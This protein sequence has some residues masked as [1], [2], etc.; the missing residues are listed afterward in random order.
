[1]STTIAGYNLLEILYEG[2][3]TCVY[4]AKACQNNLGATSVIIKTLKAEY[5]TIGQLNRLKHEYQIL[6]DLEIAEIVEPLA[7]ES[8]GNGLALILSDFDGESLAKAIAKQ[9][10]KLNNFLPIAIHL[11]EILAQLHQQNII[12]KDIKPHNILVNEKTSEVRLIDFGISTRLS[13]ESPTIDRI[14]VLEGTLSYMSP[15]Q[16][17]RMNRSIDYRTDFYSL[18]VTFYEM[19]TGQLPFPATD[20]LE[21]IH[22]HIAKTAIPPHL[23]NSDIPQA[24]SDIVMKLLAKT[25]E[26]RYQSALGLKADLEIYLSGAISGF[27]IGE[28]DL[29]SQFSIPEKLYGRDREIDLLMKTFA[30]VTDGKT[31]VM[32]VKGYSGIGKSSLVNEIR[33]PIVGARGYFISGKFD[34]FQRNIPYSAIITAFQ[35]LVKQL[36]TENEIQLTQWG[37]KLLKALGNNAQIIIDVVP[38]I[39]LIIGKQPTALEL[40]PTEAQNR[41]NVVFQKFI[42]VFCSP[43]HPLVLFLDDLQ[44]ADSAT[45]KL[46]DAILT[47]AET[48]YL[49]L[50]G[51]YRDNEVSLSHPLVI[52]LDSMLSKSIIIHEIT[53][54]PLAL[55]D[56]SNL[57]A[58]TLHNDRISVQTLAELVIRKTSGNPFFVTQFLKTLYQEN[59]LQFNS[60]APGSKAYWQWNITQIEALDITDNVVELMIQKLRKL[61]ESTQQVLQ[62]AACVGN[63]FDLQT[64]ATI[65]KRSPTVTY[66]NILPAIAEGLILPTSE[67]TLPIE[68]SIDPHLM[69]L[70]FKFLHDRVQQAAD[71]LIDDNFKQAT[72]LQIGRLLWQNTSPETLSEK[73]FEIVDHLNLGIELITDSAER[74][75]I[76]K[77]NLIAGQK[78]KAAM[79]SVAANKYLQVGLELLGN[80]SWETE[81]ELTLAL[82]TEAAESAYLSSDFEAV[83][84][85]VD[86][87]RNCAKTLLDKVKVYEIQIQAHV[88]QNK[89]LEAINTALQALKLL[90]VNFP[91][92]PVP[93]DIGQ[94]LSETAAILNGRRIEDLVDLPQMSDPYEL[95]AIKLLASIFAP[96]YIAAPT[97]L[98][99]AV[100]KQVDLSV[101]HGNAPVSP[102]AYANYGLLLCGVVG[103]IDSGYQFGQ[104]ALNLLS[105]L[106]TQ[107]IKA[108]T[109]VIVNIFIRP[110]KEHLRQTLE[111]LMSAYSIGMETGDLEFGAFG[112]LVRS[113]FAYYSSKEL[114]A[115]AREMAINRD[116]IDKIKQKTALNYHEIYWQATLNL[117]G[118]S[119]NPCRLQGEAYDEQIGLPLHEQANDRAAIAYTYLNKLLLCYLFE[120]YSE[121]L[122]NAVIEENY[123]DAVVAT[124]HISLFHFY[125]SLVKLAVYS[126]VPQSE[127]RDILGRVKANQEKIQNWA[128]HAPM[129]YLHKF[130]LVEAERHRVLGEKVEA[131]ELYDKAIAL[132]KE[133][134]YLNEEALA[135]E[136][137]AKFYLSWGKD[138]IAQLYLQ[139]AHYAYQ[140][141]GAQAK[142]EYLKEKY[143]QFLTRTSVKNGTNTTNHQ[144]TTHHTETDKNL[145]LATVMKAAQALSGEIILS[146][147]L[148]KLMQILLENAG[149]ET[150]ILI[151]E[152]S[153]QLFIEA[154]GRVNQDEIT[155]EQSIVVETSQQLPLSIINYVQQTQENVVLNDANREGIFITDSYI[156]AQQPKSVLC[157][158]IV[159]QGKLIGI[160]YLENNLTT[161]AFTAERVE[162]L[163]VLSSQAA[164][165]I[166]N[167][168]LYQDLGTANA[169]LQKSH[170]QLEDYSKTLE[171]K[172]EERT[173]Q[174]RQEVRDRQRAEE[175]AQSANRAKSEFLA[176][177]SHELRTPL[178][179]ILGYTQI[180]RKDQ[181]LSEQQKNRIAIIHQCGEHL[182]TLI[183][184]VLDLSKIEARKMELYPREFHFDEFLQSIVEIC[185]IK[186]EQKGITLIYETLSPLPK[187]VRADDK[188][189]RQILLNLLGNA[190]KFTEMGAIAFKVG[191][192]EEKIRFQIKDSGVGIAA[193]ELDEIFQPFQQ[194]G[195]NSRKTE[196]TGLGL[197]I[198]GQLVE[199]MSGKL[200]VKSSLG[201]GSTFWFDLDLPEIHSSTNAANV[202]QRTVIGIKGEKR[203]ILVVDDKPTNR[204]ILVNF[205][206][207]IGFEVLDAVDGEDGLNKAQVFQPDAILIDLVMPNLDGF[208][209]TRRLRSIPALKDIIVIAISASVFEFDQQQSIKVGCNDFLPKPIREED[210]LEKLQQHLKLEWIYEN[211]SEIGEP[212]KEKDKLENNQVSSSISPVM[213]IPSREEVAI[214][215]DLA[216]RGDLRAIA[217]RATQLEESN[218]QWSHFASHLR[219]LAKEFKGRQ[220]LEFLQQN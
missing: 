123:L 186:A 209:A 66:Q 1:M 162:V 102:T 127:Q 203:K 54:A 99:L 208:E 143:P 177:M 11:A 42:R 107:E 172:V 100:C 7:L 194:V 152:K 75:E 21:I 161:G 148:T 176:N 78:A 134:K 157:A 149:A 118:Q 33:K 65:Y 126:D 23:I 51:A 86:I 128:H 190:I 26:E 145:D 211:E 183:N 72:H 16:T 60:S 131:M 106:N 122:E 105:R 18:G 164:I 64:L 184:D 180:C 189:L 109:I 12:H 34:Q 115:L 84:R 110:W 140:V 215:L 196:G 188:R 40:A 92:N 3:T 124:P 168:R 98:P 138:A 41:F 45:L 192:H 24:V 169:D 113:Y 49:F 91:E 90:E 151:L 67:L 80:L 101:Q 218:P 88:L 136:L 142:V 156:V 87:V 74:V 111:P 198:S 219:Q 55:A 210:L 30:R 199:M 96:A 174:L 202:L 104:L 216:M 141:W 77:L 205:L 214:F 59:L 94:A 200:Q 185:K 195:E 73:I 193:D 29:F 204:S 121:A 82:H 36:L 27:K 135:N 114:T 70:G 158:P 93:S 171:L 62:L 50:L 25:A 129:N 132:A 52:A 133:N 217:K 6:Q 170:E 83:Q 182:L 32:L 108:K 14:N 187:V 220:I 9:P 163:Q 160:L 63:R 197:A 201:V 103:D 81:Y 175:I 191:Y 89:L 37:T 39:E 38:D 17:G 166:E 155:V 117:L 71:A 97:L 206:E 173:L 159:H 76:A 5:P 69:N 57:I 167:A 8:Y 153:T 95:A 56:I 154:T 85:F 79:A 213:S 19:L 44:W 119:E 58:D 48:G 146:K 147:L 212:L 4:R 46:L 53:L 20:T 165:S 35:S 150:G 130:Y 2:A 10:F 43:E 178:N 22:C 125:D 13:T 207:P 15:E 68:D 31:E 47:D 139:K 181:A 61:P 116:A 28:F 112:L 144:I 179:G 137:A 120:N